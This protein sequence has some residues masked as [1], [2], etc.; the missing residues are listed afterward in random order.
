MFEAGFQHYLSYGATDQRTVREL[1]DAFDGI[2]VPGTV[3]AFQREGTGG[4]MLTLSATQAGIPYVIDSRFPLFQ[5]ALERPK[6]SHQALAELLMDPA[7]VSGAPPVASDF[8]EERLERIARHWADFN[9]V[10]DTQQSAKFDKYARL[11]NE[12]VAPRN[13]QGPS[14]ILAPYF[15][16]RAP[17]DPWW[18]HSQRLFDL[19]RGH[20]Q[21]EVIRVVACE[22]PWDLSDLLAEVPDERV[23]VW[24]SDLDEIGTAP[25]ALAAYGLAIA[26]AHRGGTRSFALYGGFFGLLLSSVGLGGA[27]HGIGYGEYRAWLE[28]PQSGPPPA[29]YY[30]PRTHR[31]I[32][33]DLAFA[34][35]SASPD[36]TRCSCRV[37]DGGAPPDNYQDLMQHSVLA[38][39]QEVR[40]WAGLSPADAAARLGEEHDA[41]ERDVLQAALPRPLRGPANRSFEHLPRWIAALEEIDERL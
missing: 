19:T 3:A 36:I 30:L 41:F 40:Q 27:S 37:C 33:Q 4:F 34:M 28:L 38:R 17:D 23:A 6:K 21:L 26:Q 16:A 9:E 29:R 35:W 13:A 18:R 12:P 11:L 20:A 24:V 39:A 2:V 32:A 14:R 7:L 10:Y 25:D 22:E 1:T 31:Y 5:Q 15:I 8:T